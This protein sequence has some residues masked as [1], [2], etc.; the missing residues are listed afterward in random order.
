MTH[1][2]TAMGPSQDTSRIIRIHK[3][4]I[5]VSHQN[6]MRPN[7]L[8]LTTENRLAIDREL[9]H[10]M[11]QIAL[12]LI[13]DSIQSEAARKTEDLYNPEQNE[14]GLSK[15]REAVFSTWRRMTVSTSLEPRNN[16]NIKIREPR[17][18]KLETRQ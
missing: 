11:V 14:N 6:Q 5:P 3:H 8:T 13:A 18:R 10:T 2:Q 1:F 16:G 9:Q 12:R 4:S 15:I 17:D 7:A